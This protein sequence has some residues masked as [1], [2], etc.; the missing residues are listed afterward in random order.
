MSQR[1]RL[2]WRPF[3]FSLPRPLRTAAGTLAERRGW[4]LRL[5]TP[6]GAVGWGEAS[7]LALGACHGNELE[8]CGAALRALGEGC[9]RGELERRLPSLPPSVAFAVGAALAE[10]DGRVGEAA[11]GWRAAPRSAWLLPAGA[12]ALAVARSRLADAVAPRP[13]AGAR[14]AVPF[15]VKWKV[16]VHGEEEERTWLEALLE[17]LPA[18][19]RLRLD[20]NGSFSRATAGRWAAR[21]AGEGRL[22][23]LE[24]PLDP[25]DLQGLEALAERVPVALD[26]ALLREPELRER[27]HGWQV[28]RPSQEGDPRPLL[29]ALEAGQPRWMVSTSFETGLGQR[30]LAHLAALQAAGP[31]PVAPGLAPGWQAPGGLGSA[32]PEAVWQAAGGIAPPGAGLRR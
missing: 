19:A 2:A 6:E 15:T 25:A 18:D 4:L 12:E 3:A 11:G 9:A 31:T 26:E 29:R 13:A 16:G 1:I 14:A 21:L 24:Q 30:W 10:A 28:R 20:A 32:E 8:R 7:P 27:W 22:E 5:E 17:L 23:W